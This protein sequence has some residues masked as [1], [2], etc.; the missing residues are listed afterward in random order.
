MVNCTASVA[1]GVRLQQH[2]VQPGRVAFKA[3][4][5]WCFALYKN[6]THDKVVRYKLCIDIIF[7]KEWSQTAYRF[8]FAAI[9]TSNPEYPGN[10]DFFFFCGLRPLVSGR[11]RFLQND[12]NATVEISPQNVFAL[13]VRVLRALV[14]KNNYRQLWDFILD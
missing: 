6:K 13:F 5:Y 10:I 3:G 1:A 9:K 11:S 12:V 14:G 8:L 7:S 4:R 2:V